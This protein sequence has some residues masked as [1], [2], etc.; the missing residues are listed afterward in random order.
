LD[1]VKLNFLVKLQSE[2]ISYMNKI[3]ALPSETILRNIDEITATKD[4][5]VFLNQ[6]G[7]LNGGECQYLLSL[8][9]PLRLIRDQWLFN[10]KD[11]SE[12]MGYAI[13][14]ICHPE[15]ED[16]FEIGV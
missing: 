6:P 15:D 9:E 10:D 5:Y 2:Y 7:N 1:S 3:K 12:S 8:D 14:S 4:V 13:D 11:I 16:E